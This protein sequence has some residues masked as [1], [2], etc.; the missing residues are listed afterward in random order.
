MKITHS[1]FA[2]FL[3]SLSACSTTTSREKN[4]SSKTDSETVLV[5]YHVKSGKEAEFQNTLSQAWE[6]YRK[7]NLVFAKLHVIVRDS[8]DNGKTRFVEIFTWVSHSTPEHAPDSV[9]AIW[10][11]EQSLCEARNGHGGLEGGEVELL[12]PAHH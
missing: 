6:I 2:L 12:T 9:K 5:I 10:N 1:L 7:D 11:Q 4:D 8:E 3:V